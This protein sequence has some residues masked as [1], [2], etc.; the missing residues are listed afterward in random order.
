MHERYSPQTSYSYPPRSSPPVMPSPSDS[1]RLPPST[2]SSPGGDRWQ[3]S[4]YGKPTPHGYPNNIRSPTAS[5]LATYITYPSPN[6]RNSYSYHLPT[7][8]H[9][10]MRVP[11][12]RSLFDDFDSRDPRSSSPYSRSSGSSQVLA[13]SFAPPPASPTS[14]EGPRIR[15]K[16]KRVVAA[17]LKVLNETYNQTP[18]PSAEQR[19]TLAKALDMAR[20]VQIWS[21]TSAGILFLS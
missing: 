2:T 6:Q 4:Y 11:D 9:H 7:N 20:S 14:P 10:T 13:R 12:D 1:R 17:Q 8:D 16:R 5:Y 3:Q 19:R 18:F 21:V 15:K